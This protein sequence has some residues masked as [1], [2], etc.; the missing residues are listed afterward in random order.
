MRKFRYSTTR[1]SAELFSRK[2]PFHSSH[3]QSRSASRKSK[4]QHRTLLPIERERNTNNTLLES[5]RQYKDIAWLRDHINHK[6]IRR[7]NQKIF[8][9]FF[10]VQ[11]LPTTVSMSPV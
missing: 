5:H 10:H 3:C 4:K 8:I 7:K 9:I 11:G 1:A 6:Q 2:R